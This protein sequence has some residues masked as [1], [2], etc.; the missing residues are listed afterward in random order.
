[1]LKLFHQ[2]Q[3]KATITEM[4]EQILSITGYQKALNDANTLEAKVVWKTWK[5][6]CQ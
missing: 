3:K 2:V 5:N 1:M 4:T 6:F